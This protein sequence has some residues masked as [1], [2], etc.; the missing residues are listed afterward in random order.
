[1]WP[2]ST[3]QHPKQFITLP[4]LSTSLFQITLKRAVLF[5]EASD[6]IIVTSERYKNHVI[7]QANDIGI[8]FN[9][10]QLFF[11]SKRLNTLPAIL[12]GIMFARVKAAEDVLVL[13]SDHILGN[14]N[15]LIGAVQK[16]STSIQHNIA[17]FGIKPTS[18]HT[19]YGYIKPNEMIDTGLFQV[20]SF[21]EKPD[22]AT[23]ISYVSKGYLWN[24]G[25]FYFKKQFFIDALT[26]HQPAL[27]NHF[28]N[29]QDV[30]KAFDSWNQS[31]SMDYG[32]ME[33]ISTIVV[34]EVH[35]SWTDIGSFDALI[36]LVQPSNQSVQ[37]IEGSGSVLI[38][39]DDIKTVFIGVDDFILVVT[40]NGRLVCKKG[41]SQLVKDIK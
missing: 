11:E 21:K 20:E 39:D 13:P 10:S 15:S 36:D 2:L 41:Q 25:I 5:C 17:V 34:S 7:N 16:A 29:Q 4:G 12:A 30:N 26:T 35:T 19:G 27:I 1:L 32:L 28:L 9:S 14:E 18:P 33:L 23:A 6:I 37:Q 24:A 38:T 8:S 22:L 31:L 40:K 3:E